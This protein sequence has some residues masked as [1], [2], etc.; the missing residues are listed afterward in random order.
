MPTKFVFPSTPPEPLPPT[1]D[2]KAKSIDI[3]SAIKFFRVA[4][5]AGLAEAKWSFDASFEDA[6]LPL[7]RHGARMVSLE[8]L[9]EWVKAY[10]K[11]AS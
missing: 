10:Y 7:D 8:Y 5:G 11:R 2:L 3:I 1:I 6:Q 4:T 9:A